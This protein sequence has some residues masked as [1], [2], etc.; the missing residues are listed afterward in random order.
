MVII[1]TTDYERLAAI[2]KNYLWHPFTQMKDYNN[3]DPLIIERGEGIILYD[4]N[5]H[6]YYDGFS[7]VWLNVHGHN[8][9]ELN[10]AITEQLSRVAHST[11]LG[12]A[13]V[14]AIELAEKL[15]GINPKGLNK[16]FYSDSGATG[17]EIAIKMAFQYWHNQGIRGKTTFIT[18]NQA[19]H[20]DTIGAVSVGAIPLFHDVFR[21]MLFPSHVIPYPYAYRHEGGGK[22]ALEDTLTALRNLLETRADEIAALIVEP[23]VQGAGGIIVM[24]PG[25]LDEIAKLC[26][27]YGI[28][29]IADEVA[30][31]F[32]RTGAMF[33]CDLEDVSPDLMVI[34]KGLTGG[35]L[36][37]AATLATDKVYNAFIANYQEQ[38]TFFHGHSFTGNP[39]G[40]AVALASLKLFEERRMV[41]GVQKKASFVEHKLEALKNRPHVGEV[42]QKGLMIGIEL[43]RD[44]V[45]REPYDWGER[46]GVRT[47]LRARE[48]GMLTRPLG[49]VIVFIPPLS[50]T[51]ADL[52]I[53]IQILEKSIVDVTEGASIS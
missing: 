31:G 41:E 39:L 34:G 46:I 33:A 3:S 28:L 5:G 51:E 1:L 16:V 43:V 50:S 47:S 21:P 17:V 30:T 4:V 26:R 24:P 42:R 29:L 8:V 27:K 48:L 10:Q 14:P 7:S 40:C 23:I 38:K 44:K 52:D 25:C 12:M 11:L 36:P 32:G 19:Y 35:Y 9:P 22:K 45:S 20:G 37:V 15:V 13:N 49:N 53:M 2:N 6:A 18:M